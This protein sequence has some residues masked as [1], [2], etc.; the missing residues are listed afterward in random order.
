MYKITNLLWFVT[1][2][3]AEPWF[4]VLISHCHVSLFFQYPKPKIVLS[5]K[6][7]M[8][9]S[10]YISMFPFPMAGSTGEVNAKLS[11]NGEAESSWQQS[12]SDK[13][14]RSGNSCLVLVYYYHHSHR[15]LNIWKRAC[16]HTWS[17][18]GPGCEVSWRH[19]G[20]FWLSLQNAP[21]SRWAVVWLITAECVPKTS[22]SYI[23]MI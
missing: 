18:A 1:E 8:W 6:F 10:L 17:D 3:N 12:G 15:G 20:R 13:K 23:F 19:A 9:T 14:Q 5:P 22:P 4:F 11:R 7:S 2:Y 16:I 21:T